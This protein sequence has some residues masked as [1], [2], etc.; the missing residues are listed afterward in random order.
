MSRQKSYTNPKLWDMTS[1]VRI[2]KLLK[3]AYP[4]KMTEDAPTSAKILEFSLKSGS[5][6]GIY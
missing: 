1:E 4:S 2:D 6:L 5:T 3:G